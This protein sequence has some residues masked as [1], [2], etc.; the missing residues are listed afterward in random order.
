MA[1][2]AGPAEEIGLGGGGSGSNLPDDAGGGGGGKS[3]MHG[4]AQLS[5]LSNAGS[6]KPA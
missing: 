2:D 6:D 3:P 4:E 1:E 5:S